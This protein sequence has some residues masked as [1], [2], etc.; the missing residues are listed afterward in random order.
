MNT[1]RR[2]VSKLL[3]VWC[4]KAVAVALGGFCLSSAGQPAI[5]PLSFPPSGIGPITFDT[6]PGLT[7]GWSTRVLAGAN[8]D[9]LNPAQMD[10]AVQTN[11]AAMIT[12]AL[13]VDANAMPPHTS[14]GSYAFR[15][16]SA[17]QFIE[18]RPTATAYAELLLTLQNDSGS[19]K[20]T[21]GIHYDFGVDLGSG[22]QDVEDDGLYGYRVYYSLTGATGSW[23]HI[24]ELDTEGPLGATNKYAAIY[25]P[26][27]WEAG[28]FLY[29]LWI[30]DNGASAGNSP[31][32]VLTEGPYTIDNLTIS[33]VDPP[34]RLCCLHPITIEQCRDTNF[35]I[36]AL[37]SGL[38]YQWFKNG[39][40]IKEI[41]RA[42]CRERV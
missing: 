15:W 21:I 18:S 10:A 14:G 4:S 2:R 23:V 20:S 6:R 37:G 25:L 3:A 22:Q 41:G 7:N 9:I 17:R 38:N 19:D 40:A 11:T 1:V 12:N 28:A 5:T 29:F 31:G 30:D 8:T 36:I 13:P 42:S 16:N 26:A 34:P 27:A 39:N 32:T 35:S 24:P 33:L